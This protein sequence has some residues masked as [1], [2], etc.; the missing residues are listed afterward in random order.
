MKALRFIE[1][2]KAVFKIPFLES[3][4]AKFTQ[5]KSPRNLFSRMPPLYDRYPKNSN[6]L[7]RRDGIAYELDLSDYMEWLV[8]WGIKSENRDALY[9]IIRPGWCMADVGANI[10]EVTLNLAR[11][12]GTTG[13]VHSFEPDEVA[14]ARLNR[15]VELNGRPAN[16]FINRLGLGD[17]S[18]EL[19]LQQEV[20][21]NR[22]GSRIH[23]HLRE[24]QRIRIGTLDAYA[25][26]KQVERFDLVKID[27]EGY[28]LRVLR[29]AEHLIH[30]CKPVLFVELDD[31][32]LRS[33]GNSAV[34]LVS[35]LES[36]GYMHIEDSLTGL[37]VDSTQSFANCHLDILAR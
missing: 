17:R 37:P 31:Q 20:D 24:G 1:R 15:N 19:I 28:E 36:M 25:G 23:R 16:I 10:G 32:N 3:L 29:G 12:T 11:L 35:F 14:F 27:V 2:P 33:Q 30:R 22:G 7:V 26:E 8:F 18:E 4:L 6:R 9:S 5:G 34:E 21:F 13:R